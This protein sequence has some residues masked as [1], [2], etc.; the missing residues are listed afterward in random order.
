MNLPEPCIKNCLFEL[1][2]VVVRRQRKRPISFY[3]KKLTWWIS[4]YGVRFKHT[5][6]YII[7]K[8]ICF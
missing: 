7:L 1:G 4:I 2:K 6:Y 5:G 8:R 3:C